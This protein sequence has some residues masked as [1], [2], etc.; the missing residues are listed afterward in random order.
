MLSCHGD[1]HEGRCGLCNICRHNDEN[2]S[3]WCE[4][5]DESAKVVATEVECSKGC[6]F[7][8]G[9]ISMARRVTAV[10]HSCGSSPATLFKLLHY[11]ANLFEAVWKGV[12]VD[13]SCDMTY[14][15]EGCSFKQN[16][17]FGFADFSKVGEMPLKYR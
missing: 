6:H 1:V 12:L 8:V 7:T 4:D 15:K 9:W 5:I 17:L 14:H 11:V 10:V 2:V 16:D 3:V 13:G